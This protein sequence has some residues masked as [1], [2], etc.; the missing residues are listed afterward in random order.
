LLQSAPVVLPLEYSIYL[1]KGAMDHVKDMGNNNVKGVKGSNAETLAD[2]IE[3]YGVHSG[4]IAE[5][6][7]LTQRV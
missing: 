4:A 7:V 2:R 6:Q 5:L 1:E 3:R